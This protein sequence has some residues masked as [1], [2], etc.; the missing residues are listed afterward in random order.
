MKGT[1]GAPSVS[2]HGRL[3][4][5]FCPEPGHSFDND[6]Q[7]IRPYRST[8][9]RTQSRFFLPL[10]TIFAFCLAAPNAHALWLETRVTP[11]GDYFGRTFTFESRDADGLESLTVTMDLAPGAKSRPI[12]PFLDADLHVISSEGP[13]AIVPVSEVRENGRVV[14]AFDV[15]A[16][17]IGSSYLEIREGAYTTGT[18]PAPNIFRSATIDGETVRAVMGGNVFR[19]ELKDFPSAQGVGAHTAQPVPGHS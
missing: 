4:E 6:A 11:N 9:V 15:S 12:S 8:E 16:A 14:Y 13:M 17:S 19:I 1:E 5:G 10:A 18:N 2:D 3:A 7:I